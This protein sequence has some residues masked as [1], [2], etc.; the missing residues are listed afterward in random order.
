MRR[1][2]GKWLSGGCGTVEGLSTQMD[3]QAKSCLFTCLNFRGFWS[4]EPGHPWGIRD[5]LGPLW[6]NRG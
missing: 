2:Q 6:L 5:V 3:F 1:G 4:Q